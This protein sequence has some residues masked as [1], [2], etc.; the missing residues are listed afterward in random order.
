MA[1]VALMPLMALVQAA[2]APTTP[3]L[4]TTP[5]V[6]VSPQ[7]LLDALLEQA[8]LV[9]SSQPPRE[10]ELLWDLPHNLLHMV[11]IMIPWLFLLLLSPP[12]SD[13]RCGIVDT[14]S[15]SPFYAFCDTSVYGK[16]NT[17]LNAYSSSAQQSKGSSAHYLG[18]I[19]CTDANGNYVACNSAISAY[20][21][22]D[23]FLD[24]RFLLLTYI[25]LHNN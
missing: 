12:D 18:R 4:P 22:V 6:N 10:S 20:E 17:I 7:W 9:L 25:V 24:G 15:T 3:W 11:C 1:H 21:G 16:A 8:A 23:C 2:D 14:S 5:P 19:R 13:H